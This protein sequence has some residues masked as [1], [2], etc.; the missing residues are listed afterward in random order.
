MTVI[1]PSEDWI[2]DYILVPELAVYSNRKGQL[3]LSSHM[4]AEAICKAIRR[5]YRYNPSEKLWY[6]FESIV[7]VQRQT[8]YDVILAALKEIRTEFKQRM[9]KPDQK[10]FVDRSFTGIDNLHTHRFVYEVIQNM[11]ANKS[12]FVTVDDF[13]S[14]PVLLNTPDGIYNLQTNERS[15]NQPDYLC[16]QITAI[17]PMEGECPYYIAHLKFMAQGDQ[18]VMDYLEGLSGYLCTGITS[19][20]EFYWM[21]GLQNN[22][23]STLVNIWRYILN[24]Y[25]YLAPQTLFAKTYNE[26]H[27]EALMRLA[28]KRYVLVDELDGNAWN[29]AKLKAFMSGSPVAAREMR[30]STVNFLPQCKLIF[31]SNHKP[32]INANDGGIVRRLRLLNFTA[33]IPDDMKLDGFEENF[34]RPEAPHILYRMIQAAQRVLMTRKLNSPTKFAEAAIEYVGGNNQIQQFMDDCC[35]T[36]EFYSETHKN[37]FK[38]YEQWAGDNQYD[39]MSATKF[40]RLLGD[41]GYKGTIIGS[42][43]GRTGVKLT[44]SW[45]TKVASAAKYYAN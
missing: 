15:P 21:F 2:S 28:G 37:L 30:G 27:P 40:G 29:E 23:K 22:G 11:Q 17:A 14:D 12:I 45:K 7:W 16:R 13:D 1:R 39:S 36:S 8:I 33:Q 6:Q 43:R 38:A 26:P 35:E 9:D 18:S 34:L 10:D 31:T 4:L 24:N 19:L 32:A 44:E 41:L 42:T 5:N 3:V 20:Q 25:F